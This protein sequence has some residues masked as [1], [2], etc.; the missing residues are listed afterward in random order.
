MKAIILAGGKGRRLAPFT[1]TIPKPL[2]PVGEKTILE[3][4]IGQLRQAKVKN[5]TF[6]VGY[7]AELIQAYFKDGKKF[8]VSINYAIERKPLGT[9]GPL[10]LLKNKKESFLV[11]NGDVLT[12]MDFKDLFSFHKKSKAVA[13]I[14]CYNK[15]VKSSLGVVEIDEKDCLRDY[16]EKPVFS[17][18]VSTGIYCF[19]PKVAKYLK[20]D[21][22][23]DLPDLMLRLI[24]AGEKVKVYHVKDHWFDIGT[25]D[26]YARAVDFWNKKRK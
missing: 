9:A 15:K 17:H 26:D 2:F 19:N 8:G 22:H 24:N 23:I 3:I 12:T 21:E 13:T 18:L 20:K 11:M 16:K 4:I 5:L 10:H 14:C 7:L 6:A 25:P 1:E